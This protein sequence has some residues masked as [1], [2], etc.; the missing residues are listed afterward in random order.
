MRQGV[1][2]ETLSWIEVGRFFAAN[3]VV[4]TCS[5]LA[6]FGLTRFYVLNTGLSTLRVLAQNR[7]KQSVLS[8]EV[9]ESN[10]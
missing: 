6:G 7:T 8:S 2:L 4:D 1:K 3:P 10:D 5:S 9:V